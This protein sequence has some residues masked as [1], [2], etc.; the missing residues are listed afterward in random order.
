MQTNTLLV[1]QRL[2]ENGKAINRPLYFQRVSST[3]NI[4]SL[5]ERSY[6]VATMHSQEPG[7]R[8][9]LC[10]P[11][12]VPNSTD[13]E[14]DGEGQ[15]KKINNT[16]LVDTVVVRSNNDHVEP[17]IINQSLTLVTWMASGYI[18]LSF[19]QGSQ[20]YLQFKETELF[21]RSRVVLEEVVWLV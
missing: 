17:L 18:C 11:S 20:S 14:Q 4:C 10:I 8:I 13:S 1:F 6:S 5:E 7:T 2:C 16:M 3:Y 21:D 12:F 15:D 19:C 9:F